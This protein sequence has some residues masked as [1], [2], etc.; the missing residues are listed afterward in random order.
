MWPSDPV[1]DWLSRMWF[2]YITRD[3]WEPVWFNKHPKPTKLD[4]KYFIGIDI[5][6]GPSQTGYSK[7]WLGEDGIWHH[8]AIS[9]DEFYK[10]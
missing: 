8:Q 7:A 9:E 3:P 5:A 4:S 2:K 1:R 6:S 10:R